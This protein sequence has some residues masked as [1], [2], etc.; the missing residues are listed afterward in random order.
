MIK[1]TLDK[2]D[3]PFENQENKD[4]IY[5]ATNYSDLGWLV[6]PCLPKTKNPMTPNG[7]YDATTERETISRWFNGKKPNIAVR[8]GRES[9]VFILDVDNKPEANK[10][11]SHELE[12]LIAEHGDLPE[13]PTQK[14]GG[15]MQYFFRYPDNLNDGD[16]IISKENAVARGLDTRGDGGYTML[17]PSVHPNGKPYEWFIELSPWEV[18]L[19]DPPEWL[20]QKI[21]RSKA[22]AKETPPTKSAEET[23][24]DLLKAQQALK[25]IPADDHDTWLNI[26]MALHSTAAGELAYQIWDEW[27]R[28]SAKYDSK[29]QRLSSDNYF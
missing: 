18:P 26:G 28:K 7:F 10:Y 12:Q 29:D 19:A 22:P 21:I 6:F 20:L 3:E 4:F 2:K 14:T 13:T 23:A 1:T 8:T 15:G 11:G 9:K 24:T 16:Y 27:S 5:S 25:T 17:P